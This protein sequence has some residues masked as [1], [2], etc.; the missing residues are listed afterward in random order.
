VEINGARANKGAA[1]QSL[2]ARLGFGTSAAMAFGDGFNDLT[3]IRQA[4]VG[5]AMANSVQTVLD[6]ADLL[7]P[8][9]DEDGVARVLEPLLQSRNP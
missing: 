5:V 4:G 9:N 8:S 6:A 3:M 2:C 1:L 7:A